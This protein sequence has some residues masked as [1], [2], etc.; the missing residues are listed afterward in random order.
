MPPKYKMSQKLNNTQ[1]ETGNIQP[2]KVI[3]DFSEQFWDPSWGATWKNIKE[4]NVRKFAK[5]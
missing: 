2:P 1:E 3:L 4:L 5:L